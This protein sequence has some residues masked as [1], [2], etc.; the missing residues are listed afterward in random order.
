MIDFLNQTDQLSDLRSGL[1]RFVTEKLIPCEI[2]L[3]RTGN[4]PDNIR[5]DMADMG[6]FGLTIDRTWGGLQLSTFE[7][8]V[9]ITEMGRTAPAFHS[10]F[11]TNAGIGSD[12]LSRHGSDAQKARYLPAMASGDIISSLAVTEPGA[13]SDLRAVSTRAE[14]VADGFRLTGQKCYI[15]NA[16]RA[17]LFTVLARCEAGLS[18]FLVDRDMPGLTVGAPERTLGHSGAPV[19]DVAFN[20][21][22]IPKEVRLG[23]AG[24]GLD[25]CLSAIDRGRLRVAALCVGMMNRL[26]NEAVTHSTQRQQFGRSLSDFQLIQHHLANCQVDHDSSL[27]LLEHVATKADKEQDIS[28]DTASAKLF[29]SEAAGRV[30]DRV[31]QIWG[32]SGYMRDNA[33]A[34]FFADARLMRIYEGTSEIMRLTIA[35][36]M[37]QQK[38]GVG[39]RKNVDNH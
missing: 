12:A 6:L 4:V 15:T 33:P 18:L 1:A 22:H 9:L 11:G 20:G 23:P 36:K 27:A 25:V 35:R 24:Q 21:C 19:A 29:A 2:E 8:I 34:R 13:G 28:R 3:D 38:S 26:I 39:M 7:E 14:T 5:K 37:V 30:A 16:S 17:D 10:V 32:G 31:V